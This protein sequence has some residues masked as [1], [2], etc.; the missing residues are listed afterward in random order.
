MHAC[1]K[2]LEGG[3]KEILLWQVAKGENVQLASCRNTIGKLPG[4]L[5]STRQVA[6]NKN[7]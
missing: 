3:K 7:T 6:I 4:A 5:I 2:L 1:S